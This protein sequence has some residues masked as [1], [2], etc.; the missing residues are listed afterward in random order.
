GDRFAPNVVCLP[1]GV[2]LGHVEPEGAV[3]VIERFDQGLIDL[4][5]YRG[6]C[7]YDFPT[8]AAES[9]VR[10]QLAAD[11]LDDVVLER[12]R[13]LPDGGVEVVFQT[14]GGLRTIR[15]AVEHEGPPR[16]ITCRTPEAV[17]P[18]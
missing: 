18:S 11:R 2:Y 1:A 14:P 12:R 4:A 15:V 5:R 16:P 10:E 7:A 13:G 9:F 3:E 6:R 17:P 8:Q